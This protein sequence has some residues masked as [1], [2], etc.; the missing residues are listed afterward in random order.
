MI[1]HDPQLMLIDL[2]HEYGASHAASE[3]TP[4]TQEK[5]GELEWLFNTTGLRNPGKLLAQYGTSR[6]TLNLHYSLNNI[7]D[8]PNLGTRARGIIVN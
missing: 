2:V 8:V 1:I 6:S 3:I 7:E 5:A 4:L